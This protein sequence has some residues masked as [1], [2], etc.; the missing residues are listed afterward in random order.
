M[1]TLTKT[2]T[3]FIGAIIIAFIVFAF[4]SEAFGQVMTARVELTESNCLTTL[5][6]QPDLYQE[7]LNRIY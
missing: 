2:I 6:S 7:L 5:K 3:I 4:I 1:N